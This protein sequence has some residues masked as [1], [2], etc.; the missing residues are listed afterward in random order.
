MSKN[1]KKGSR[2]EVDGRIRISILDLSPKLHLQYNTD[3]PILF[4]D[5]R[6]YSLSY[7]T[8]LLSIKINKPV[9]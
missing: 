5:Y 9:L 2:C 4:V 3:K 8:I 6:V 7:W 1:Y